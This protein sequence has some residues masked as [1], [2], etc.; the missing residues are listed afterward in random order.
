MAVPVHHALLLLLPSP[1]C[2]LHSMTAGLGP[3][4]SKDFTLVYL[5][6]TTS[7]VLSP[8][9]RKMHQSQRSLW[10]DQLKAAA[11]CR[12][13]TAVNEGDETLFLITS[14]PWQG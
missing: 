3:P 6:V 5:P 10:G 13:W 2:W 8:K 14:S 1:V 4:H 7:G 9:P 12:G 11:Y